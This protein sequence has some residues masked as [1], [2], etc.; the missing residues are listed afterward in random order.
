MKFVLK[1]AITGA[2]VWLATLLPLDVTVT[3]GENNDWWVRALVFLLVGAVLVALNAIVKPII[4][5]VAL[6]AIILTLGLF[7]LV[8]TWFILWL[9]SW[10]TQLDFFSWA[11]LDVGGFWKTLGAAVVIAI[12]SAIGEAFLS[13]AKKSKS[14]DR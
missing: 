1:S 7:S 12:A 8:I 4:K 14:R 5:L 11:T 9:T 6:P 13:T 10:I 2:A 3:G